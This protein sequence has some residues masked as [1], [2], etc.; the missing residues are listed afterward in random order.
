MPSLSRLFFGV[1]LPSN[2]KPGG[3]L[4]R[5]LSH[6]PLRFEPLEGRQLLSVGVGSAVHPAAAALVG[7]AA[8]SIP[9]PVSPVSISGV[10]VAEAIPKDGILESS[11][12]AVIS[13]AFNGATNVASKS[14]SVDGVA[15]ANLYGP[16]SQSDGSFIMSG[17]PGKL[18]A[19]THSYTIQ[20]ADSQG[21]TA[22]AT[23]TF[24]VMPAPT[25]PTIS[26]VVANLKATTPVLTWNVVDNNGIAST[27]LTIDGKAVTPIYGPYGTYYIANYAGAIGTLL[28]GQ[29]SYVI[30]ATDAIGGSTTYNGTITVPTIS[31]TV[32]NLPAT[33]PVITWNVSDTNAITSSSITVDSKAVAVVYGPFGTSYNANYAG[34]IGQLASGS[35]SYVITA[36][37]SAGGSSQFT[38]TFVVGPVISGVVVSKAQ[39]EI[40]WNT[41]DTVAL[42]SLSLVLDNTTAATIYGPFSTSNYAGVFGSLSA[43]TH[44][45][46]ISVTNVQGLTTTFDG[47]FMV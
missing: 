24:N 32:V 31:G 30:T 12:D 6:R 17:L 43:G 18:S 15:V 23:G 33:V 9:V 36:T 20:T 3:R 34:A 38:G 11:D 10:V 40:T 35:H 16:I 26:G 7:S 44:T 19:G 13:W 5:N 47:T 4:A 45:Y 1:R 28:A 27:S 14:L 42:A 41:A 25:A 46:V 37:D 8:P 21:D 22:T 39:S 2:T 29:H